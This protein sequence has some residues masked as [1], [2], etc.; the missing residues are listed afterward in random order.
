MIVYQDEKK[1]PIE[2][3]SNHSIPIK[4]MSSIYRVIV[5]HLAFLC[6]VSETSLTGL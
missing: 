2:I 6:D 5:Y 1:T 3:V 4:K